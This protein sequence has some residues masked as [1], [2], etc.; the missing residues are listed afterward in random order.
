MWWIVAVVALAAI[1]IGAI[2]MNK[3]Q[4][5]SADNSGA[6]GG[7]SKKEP[8]SMAVTSES[9]SNESRYWRV[10]GSTLEDDGSFTI[11]LV[12]VADYQGTAA[13]AQPP[14]RRNMN[15]NQ[16]APRGTI[17]KVTETVTRVTDRTITINPTS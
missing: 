2:I 15:R 14:T 1:V 4:K 13:A 6:G 7:G 3:R 5:S 10:T 9:L 16:D 11:H 17:L 12:E 8:K